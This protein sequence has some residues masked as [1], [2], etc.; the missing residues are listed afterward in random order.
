[1][2]SQRKRR[3]ENQALCQG[4]AGPWRRRSQPAVVL[5]RCAM[6]TAA[7]L[8][9]SGAGATTVRIKDL[10]TVSGTTGHQLIGYGLVVG[11]DGTGDSN[12]ALFTARSLA[13]M[14]EQ[15]GITVPAETMRAD[16]V[17]A[18]MVT[19]EL[20]PEAASGTRLDVTVSS[21]G[22]AESL[23][24]GTLLVTPLLGADGQVCAIAQ[25]SVSI[26]G[27]NVSAGGSKVQKN[28]P[29]VGRVP[30]GA[31]VTRA[32]P[33]RVVEHQRVHLVLH[34]PDFTTAQRVADA[35][36]QAFALS[37][38]QPINQAAVEVQVPPK[39]QSDLV[40]FVAQVESVPVHPD[41]PARVVINERT[42]TVIIGGNVRILPVAIAHG[43]LTIQ[44]KT[45]WEVSQPPP[46]ISA[47]TSENT[48]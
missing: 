40:G 45:R 19:A 6:V 46:L 22:D 16:N 27:F 3:L 7:V 18:V 30:N 35:V 21:I 10:A 32:V 2:S 33:R 13:N 42:G 8:L 4:L 12:R 28:H 39:W 11:L 25:G 44:V 23:Q 9:A 20:S 38:A 17:A 48:T 43:G 26:G 41:V 24:G 37:I 36:N 31:T 15:F 34:N 47:P 1:M 14:L 29:V 5:L